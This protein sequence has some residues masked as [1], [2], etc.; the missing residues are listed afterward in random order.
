M[1]PRTEK[2]IRYGIVAAGVVAGALVFFRS[3]RANRPAE[4]PAPPGR[5]V[6]VRG[7]SIHVLSNNAGSGPTVVFESALSCP[8]TE[9]AWVLRSLD[10]RVPY[11]AYDRPGNGWSSQHRPPSSAAELN[12]LT[13]ELLRTL[14]L[15]APYVLVG[16]SIGGLLARTFAGNHPESTAGLVLV[17]SSHPDQLE[18]S[19]VQREGM[20]L[21][22]QGLA[23]MYWRARFG[24]VGVEGGFGAVADLPPELATM[25]AEIMCFPEPWKGAGREFGLWHSRWSGEVR[26]VKD[27]PALPIAVI[28]AGTQAAA[29]PVH[30]KLQQQLAGLSAMSRHDIVEKADHDSLVMAE[31]HANRVTKVVKWTLARAV[32]A[33]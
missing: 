7:E 10:G 33:R 14:G 30:G 11:L 2:A 19:Q 21:V 18:V 16:H 32:A 5:L 9:W 8:C 17:D 26:S 31:E 24:R 1:N 25:T 29:D 23:T 6:D 4:R 12:E 20:P 22:A 27:D 13:V 3:V 15:P 28:T